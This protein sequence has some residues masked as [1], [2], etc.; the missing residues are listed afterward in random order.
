M[1]WKELTARLSA[2][3]KVRARNAFIVAAARKW[4]SD[5]NFVWVQFIPKSYVTVIKKF[6]LRNR[7]LQINMTLIYHFYTLT[8]I[9]WQEY[10]Y[11]VTMKLLYKWFKSLTFS[12]EWRALLVLAKTT[13]RGVTSTARPSENITCRGVT[14]TARHAAPCHSFVYISTT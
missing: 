11:C 10:L 14:S 6:Y 2:A 13:C 4:R 7:L 3:R 12:V 9:K 5:D 8:Y 1:S